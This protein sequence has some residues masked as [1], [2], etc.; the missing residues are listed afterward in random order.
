MA[1]RAVADVGPRVIELGPPGGP[2]LLYLRTREMGGR[3]EPVWRFRGGWRLWT[4]PEER[5]TTYALDNHACTVTRPDD[6]TLRVIGPPSACS[7]QAF[8]M[9]KTVTLCADAELPRLRVESR[10][11][12]VGTTAVTVAPWTLAVLRPGGRAFVPLDPGDPAALADVRRLVLWSYTRLD[13]PRYAVGRRL[14]E[15]DHRAV[16]AGPAPIVIAPGRKSDE[17]KIGVDARAGW[18]AYLFDDLLLVTRA[19]VADGPRA[20]GTTVECYSCREFI[21]LEHVGILA[22]I[23]P[24]ADAV[25][26]EDWWLFTDVTLPD[27]AAGSDAVREAL[28]P[29]VDRVLAAPL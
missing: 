5:T 6:A 16:V 25:L 20:S 26:H 9:Q 21:E 3:G 12:N 4:A 7:L 19:E 24:D 13:D 14:V 27:P 8:S 10:I 23:A 28:A 29:Y 18:A 22:P 2:S 15:V 1:A 17:S 11:R